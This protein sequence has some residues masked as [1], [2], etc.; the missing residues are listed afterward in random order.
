MQ[1]SKSRFL[2]NSNRLWNKEN[3][4]P[5]EGWFNFC[6]NTGKTACQTVWGNGLRAGTE[7][8]PHRFKFEREPYISIFN[9]NNFILTSMLIFY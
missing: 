9:F 8:F 7:K 5:A 6:P 2:H 1:N 4:N 3:E